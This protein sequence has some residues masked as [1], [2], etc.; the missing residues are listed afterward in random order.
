MVYPERWG[1]ELVRERAGVAA[2]ARP[3]MNAD[4]RSPP[5]VLHVANPPA[6]E[7]AFASMGAKAVP[8]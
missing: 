3:V 5:P 1:G 6:R 4:H 8:L 7:A 2:A